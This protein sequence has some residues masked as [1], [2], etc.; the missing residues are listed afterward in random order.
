MLGGERRSLS[1]PTETACTGRTLRNE[2]ALRIGDRDQCV[3]ERRRNMSD[4]DGDVLPL[5]LLKSLFL[6]CSFSHNLSLV[7][8]VL[9][10][11]RNALRLLTQDL[12]LQTPDYFLPG[13]FFFATAALR[14]PFRVLALVDVR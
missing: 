6:G 3:V 4:P 11:K 9:S 5:F 10:L 12:R 1:R 13:A 8:F 14:G 7:S 2:I